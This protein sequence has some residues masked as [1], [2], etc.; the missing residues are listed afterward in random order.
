MNGL[1]IFLSPRGDLWN[2]NIKA[3]CSALPYSADSYS[4]S[5]WP[6][7][8]STCCWALSFCIK[9]SAQALNMHIFVIKTVCRGRSVSAKHFQLPQ[10]VARRGEQRFWPSQA[11]PA[12]R[13]RSCQWEIS[14]KLKSSAP[15]ARETTATWP[16]SL[17]RQVAGRG[18]RAMWIKATLEVKRAGRPVACSQAQFN[19]WNMLR[20]TKSLRRA[21]KLQLTRALFLDDVAVLIKARA[22]TKYQS[23]P[24]WPCQAPN[25]VNTLPHWLLS[26]HCSSV[27]RTLYR[28][29]PLIFHPLKKKIM[30]HICLWCCASYVTWNVHIR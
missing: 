9:S 27:L 28:S 24:T 15:P 17:G 20:R 30:N 16:N 13:A 12:S 7:C 26:M 14:L 22:S 5:V 29:L 23:A 21:D 1:A 3:H 10:L 25:Y 6:F 2:F 11:S 18:E 4:Y 19:D 8:N